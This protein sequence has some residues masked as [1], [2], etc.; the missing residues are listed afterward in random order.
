MACRDVQLRSDH[1]RNRRCCAHRP[2]KWAVQERELRVSGQEF[3]AE[4]PGAFATVSAGPPCRGGE[5]RSVAPSAGQ[6]WGDRAPPAADIVV[7]GGAPERLDRRDAAAWA[8][9]EARAEAPERRAARQPAASYFRKWLQ[10]REIR[11]RQREAPTGASSPGAPSPGGAE[12]AAAAAERQ[13]FPFPEIPGAAG[14]RRG[15]DRAGAAKRAAPDAREQL[16]MRGP[17]VRRAR[18]V[19]A[20]WPKLEEKADR[21]KL[22]AGEAEPLL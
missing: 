6:P 20:E 1:Q 19:W 12:P 14:G 15:S 7:G 16:A 5:A 2:D 9:A 22:T 11:Q 4:G 3:R 10:T 18:A 17:S 13:A 21:L 8:D